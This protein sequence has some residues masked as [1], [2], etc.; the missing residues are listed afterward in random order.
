MEEEEAEDEELFLSPKSAYLQRS[1]HGLEG[2]VEEEGLGGVVLV[3]DGRGPVSEQVCGV[4]TTG[5]PVHLVIVP[6]VVA[7]PV[8]VAAT[9]NDKTDDGLSEM[10]TTRA[11]RE[12]TKDV[13]SRLANR[14]VLNWGAGIAWVG[15]EN[16]SD[17]CR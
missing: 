9:Q 15:A 14:H 8:A 13:R 12:T 4:V 16:C 3:D 1:V 17:K 10:K 11:K 2:Q 6:K 7:M 5:A